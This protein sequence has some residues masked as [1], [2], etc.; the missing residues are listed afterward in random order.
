MSA[1]RPRS[2]HDGFSL[3]EVLIALA[4]LSFG[5]LGVAALQVAGVRANGGAYY[6][7]QAMALANDLTERIYANRV[8]AQAGNYGGLNFDVRNN[9][10]VNLCNAAPNP[11][12]GAQIG[13]A[14]AACTPAQMATYDLFVIACGMPNG[15]GAFLGGADDLLP[16]AHV[17]VRCLPQAGAVAAGNVIACPVVTPG[18]PLVPAPRIWIKI[19]WVEMFNDPANARQTTQFSTEQVNAAQ[20]GIGIN[21]VIQP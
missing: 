4:I 3:I 19:D 2:G 9:V 10:N 7:S 16:M 18:P 6:R 12:C 8:G 11:V 5:L 15:L 17:Q 1:H 21:L 14:G 13:S 20:N